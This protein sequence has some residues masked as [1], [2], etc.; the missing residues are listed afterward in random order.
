MVSY[1]KTFQ[2]KIFQQTIEKD[3]G[4]VKNGEQAPH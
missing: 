3:D 4:I 2:N 1:P